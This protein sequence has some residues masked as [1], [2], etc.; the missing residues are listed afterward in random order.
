[1]SKIRLPFLCENRG[2]LLACDDIL[3]LQAKK[4]AYVIGKQ[5][6]RR[7]LSKALRIWRTKQRGT[8]GHHSY[9]VTVN[10][11]GHVLAELGRERTD[12]KNWK[13]KRLQK[14][15]KK[16]AFHT[17]SCFSGGSRRRIRTL[18]NRVRAT[19]ICKLFRIFEYF[20]VMLIL[21]EKRMKVQR[22]NG[23]FLILLQN[24]L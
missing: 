13:F 19:I 5:S 3:A 8:Q 10:T 7:F 4:F 20:G 11:Y 1:M 22:N 2:F 14:V 6:H 23:Y 15:M 24:K 18:T 17:K 21:S 16:A 9:V 12:T